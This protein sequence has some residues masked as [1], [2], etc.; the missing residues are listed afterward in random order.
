MQFA[1]VDQ[2]PMRRNVDHHGPR[3]DHLCAASL[4]ASG[5][6][7]HRVDA[8]DHLAK[9]ERLDYVVVRAELEPDDAVDLLSTRGDDDDRDIRPLAEL[10]A[11]G[12]AVDIR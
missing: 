9:A 3:N 4:P 7:G 12:E 2:H 8:R 11:H 6:A 1:T 10:S 5:S